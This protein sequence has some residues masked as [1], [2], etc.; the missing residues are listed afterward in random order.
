VSPVLYA[1]D[2][3]RAPSLRKEGAMQKKQFF[4][5]IDWL[6]AA[7]NR[8]GWLAQAGSLCDL[9]RDRYRS[10]RRHYSIFLTGWT[11]IA[12]GSSNSKRP[13]SRPILNAWAT[14]LTRSSV[15]C[16]D[17]PTLILCSILISG[18]RP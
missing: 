2:A 14:M 18:W 13:R 12:L 11:S 8:K 10:W 4:E 17:M 1:R 5:E 3:R 9:T 7:I 16:L 6:A 15:S